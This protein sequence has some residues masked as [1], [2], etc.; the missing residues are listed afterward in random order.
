M[1]ETWT[2]TFLNAFTKPHKTDKRFADVNDRASKLENGSWDC[3]QD[4]LR[5]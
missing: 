3:V 5:E 2:D 1:L 4:S